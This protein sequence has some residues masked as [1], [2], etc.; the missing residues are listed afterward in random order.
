MP[1]PKSSAIF[2]LILLGGLLSRR[3]THAAADSYETV[4]DARPEPPPRVLDIRD[5]FGN[6]GD[7]IN[8]PV[9]SIPL[10]NY[11]GGR[12]LHEQQSLHTEPHVPS[13]GQKI[14]GA[15]RSLQGDGC[16]ITN[17]I[18]GFNFTDNLVENRFT[19]VPPDPQGAA[20]TSRLVAVVN[21]MV[22]AR[23]KNGTLTFRNGFQTFFA[24]FP[25]AFDTNIFGN[26]KVIYDEHQG[27]FVIG[28]L[29]FSSSQSISRFWLAVSKDET[30]D[31][32]DDWYKVYINSVVSIDG[33]NTG[34]FS[35][36]LEV[37]EE[38]V[39]ITSEVV[40][41]PR[42][43]YAGVRIWTINK[44]ID[45]GLYAGGAP[46]FLIA[47]PYANEG[48]ALPTVPA[49]VHG[50]NGVDGSVGTFFLSTLRYTGGRVDLQ[51]ATVFNPLGSPTYTVRFLNLGVITSTSGSLPSAPQLGSSSK[52]DVVD[53]RALD[54]VWR[55]NTLWV[56]FM[57]N[58]P[59]GF[60]QNQT[61][62]HWVRLKTSGGIVTLE[63]QGDLGGESIA[64][65]TFTYYPSVA[66]NS[67]GLV[68]FG[69]GASAPT[70]YAGAYASVGTSE[71]SYTVK[72]GLAPYNRSAVNG[73]SRWGDYTGISVDPTDDSFWVFNQYAETMGVPSSEG[74]G[75]WGTAW[76]RLACGVRVLGF[77]CKTFLA[78]LNALVFI[79]VTFLFQPAATPAPT[80]PPTKAPTRPPTKA[81]TRPPTK[82]PTRP[83]TRAPTRPPT[84]A[85]SRPPT[86]APTRPPSKAP[87]RP[88]SKAPTR[89]PTT[90]PIRPP[91]SAPVPLLVPTRKPCGLF[92]L[93]LFC[94]LTFC[95]LIGTWLGFCRS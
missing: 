72:G 22:E 9:P 3:F 26:P 67:L 4:F 36:Q 40:Q 85:P 48:I 35:L 41:L 93:S 1:K 14:L 88:P 71:Q 86:K 80:R 6:S 66:V 63:A 16:R 38:A 52:I 23:H 53:S 74:N 95:G 91:L 13:D 44:G 47:N 19:V 90:V 84:K 31:T 10:E 56:V 69:Y 37:D 83:P 50:T 54:A 18:L 29:Q 27:H 59:I 60:N 68:A 49:Q 25:E 73:E 32:I 75:R 87:S 28:V 46:S 15:S 58:P 55:N 82:A 89:P 78:T 81:P 76:G 42:N 61:S 57:I 77:L 11:V 94:P 12:K 5:G 34:A 64:A 21:S 7:A 43:R 24:S 79:V 2:S 20:G 39:Y 65:G 30:P 62:A 92:G 45:S 8:I 70:T 17:T 51:I 33:N